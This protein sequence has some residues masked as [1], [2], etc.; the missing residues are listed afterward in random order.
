MWAE[1]HFLRPGW[2][3]LLP[4]GL[5][6]VWS[7]WR[8]MFRSSNWQ[9][10]CDPA[11]LAVLLIGGRA[12]RQWLPLAGLCLLW[13]LGVFALAGPAWERQPQPVYSANDSR[14]LLFDLSQS[15]AS[16]D[17]APSRLQRARY[18]LADLVR[19][20]VDRQQALIVFAGDAWVV[21]PFTDDNETLLNLAPSLDID[22]APMQGSRTD[23]ALAAAQKL[24]R[25][26]SANKVELILITDGMASGQTSAGSLEFAS[27]LARDGHKL[28]VLGVGTTTGGPVSLDDGSLLKDAAG[29]I[30]IP[31]I[32]PDALSVLADTG[33]GNLV[34]VSA[35]NSDI[36]QLI[37]AD[38]A[39]AYQGFS[40]A[41]E[42][43]SLFGEV[44]AD[45]W[46]D[47]GVW[48]LWPLL[49][50]G[51]LCFRRGWLLCLFLM[52]PVVPEP[53]YAFEWQDLWL[54]SDQRAAT[55]ISEKDYNGVPKNADQV[56]Q[57]I[58]AYRQNQMPQATEA[59]ALAQQRQQTP[60]NIYNYANA[61]AR[62]GQLEEAI[63]AYN[64][65]LAANP[66]FED[67]IHNRDLVQKRLQQ[68]QQSG[69]GGR[70]NEQNRRQNDNPQ[71]QGE[72]QPRE[73]GKSTNQRIGDGQEQRPDNAS[74]S[75]TSASSQEQQPNQDRP[76]EQ[77][78]ADGQDAAENLNAQN[79]DA[80]AAGKQLN[81]SLMG[82]EQQAMEQWLRKIPDDP[83]GLLRRKFQ[84]QQSLR[85]TRPPQV[86]SW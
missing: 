78:R 61:L 26:A 54:R 23:L 31:A 4:P 69:Q 25:N 9:R 53:V 29:N 68:Q 79:R 40:G 27:A 76:S 18:K 24:I 46:F 65:A 22:T 37:T 51:A 36:D 84:H 56:W 52:I 20:G 85:Q 28:H 71:Q 1:F 80:S 63:E 59:F 33:N 57:G 81:S 49:I 55:A 16:T 75:S 73:S 34:M 13:S 47:R 32:D 58:S 60:D 10:H 38:V 19:A 15:M 41:V 43:R 67:A 8:G 48:L 74:E 86:Q 5:L 66:D 44:R 11:L 82:E 21:A 62:S 7:L 70:G 39:D 64:M 35:D 6:L 2:L 45:V 12:G 14:I 30:V 42:S 3:I 83:G 50:F 77:T 72:Q 17:I